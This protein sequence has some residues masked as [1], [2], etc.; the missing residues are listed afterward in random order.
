MKH[1][2]KALS[3][4][5]ILYS[6]IAGLLGS[7]PALPIV[8]ETIRLLY[9]HL[10]MWFAMFTLYLISVI[11]SI[12]YL[13]SGKLEHDHIAVESVNVGIIFCGLGLATGMLWANFTW[14]DPWPND[15]KVNGSAIATLMYLAYL[16]LRNALEEEQKRAKIGAI[17]NIFAF[18]VMIVLMYILPKMT[19]SLHPGSGGNSGFGEFDLNNSMKLVLYPASLGWILMGLWLTQIRYRIRRLSQRLF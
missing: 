6:L 14:G 11:Y 19:D 17:Y 13:N 12:R 2:W 15:A 8:N 10:P 9:Y 1:W 7:V 18:P 16:V 4:L 3:V 5:L